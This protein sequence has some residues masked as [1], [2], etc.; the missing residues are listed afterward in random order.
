MSGLFG[1]L[2]LSD[3][4]YRERFGLTFEDFEVG[5]RIHHRP[6]LTFTQQDNKD[7][8]LDTINNAHLHY[9][10]A[11]AAATEWGLPLGV[12]TVTLQLALGMSSRSFYRRRDILGVDEITMTRPVF[13]GETLYALTEVLEKGPGGDADCGELLLRTEAL[14]R[15]GDSV[16]R[17]R[18]RI[19]LYRAGRH[20]EE[21]APGAAAGIIAQEERFCLHHPGPEGS[22][23]EQTGLF[24]E[25]FVDGETF[26][27]WPPRYFAAEESR[28][29]ALR[30]LEI[31][32]RYSNPSFARAVTGAEP[33]LFEPFVI[34]AVTS[35]TTRTFGRVVANLGWTDIRLPRPVRPE[36]SVRAVSSI[37]GKRE[38][39]KRPDQ[40]ILQVET[41][42]LGEDG[43]TVCAF[44]RVLLVYK[45]G[46]GPYAA[47]GY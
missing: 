13:G 36:E 45:R 2:K 40:G 30:A 41:S 3:G 47:A 21:L 31:N 27:H 42:A 9:D 11:Y 25:D 17:V 14:N 44:N 10:D 1:Y 34:G 38:S 32:P 19:S 37:V 20:P 28:R 22:L 8:S 16:M 5:Q 6:G 24:F 23:V 46:V 35:L 43:E 15:A 7:E 12:S 39:A 18:Y 33:P 29:H 26:E 4:R